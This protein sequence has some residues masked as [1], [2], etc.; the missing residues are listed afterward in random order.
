MICNLYL[1][2]MYDDESI[3]F[4]ISTE[5]PY[6][7]LINSDIQRNLLENGEYTMKSFVNKESVQLILDY[8]QNREIP[9]IDESNKFDLNYLC[10]EFGILTN[11]IQEN[12][13][14]SFLNDVKNL[15]QPPNSN[16]PNLIEKV[17]QNLD[18][19]LIECGDELLKVPIQSL[20]MIFNLSKRFTKHNL[21][22]YLILQHSKCFNDKNIFILLPYL[23]GSQID[24]KNL[25]DAIFNSKSRYG[26]LPN[27]E[28]NFISEMNDKFDQFQN[29][30]KK[31]NEKF[32]DE[33]SNH[34]DLLNEIKNTEQNFEKQLL[35]QKQYD[36]ERI[37]ELENE[38]QSLKEKYQ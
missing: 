19:Y 21:C 17:A 36:E 31:I 29:E 6:F 20:N 14:I 23:D 38:I 37:K 12:I 33:L 13:N 30:Q 26:F 11:E 4:N 1:V 18:Q 27:I 15:Q 24:P 7:D 8:L 25:D 9:E 3:E 10:N 28:F 22:Y 5:W 32:I 35:R 16:T 34:N 2:D